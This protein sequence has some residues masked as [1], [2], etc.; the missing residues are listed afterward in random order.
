MTIDVDA[1]ISELTRVA[2]VH[3]RDFS[4]YVPLSSYRVD[5]LDLLSAIQGI[6]ELYDITIPDSALPTL[7]CGNDI[8]SYLEAL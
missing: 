4:I 3:P 7:K 5:S 2:H 1:V 6:E 8:I